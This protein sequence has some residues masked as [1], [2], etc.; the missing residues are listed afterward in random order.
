MKKYSIIKLCNF[1]QWEKGRSLFGLKE[2]ESGALE[3][4]RERVRE[5]DL[6]C[7]C[8]VFA[9][10]KFKSLQYFSG[11]RKGRGGVCNVGENVKTI[12]MESVLPE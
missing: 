1:L 10:I 2:R 11:E 6:K 9:N 8:F 5:G 12:R 3:R 7:F 4:E